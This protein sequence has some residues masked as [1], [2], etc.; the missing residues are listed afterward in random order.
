MLE[1]CELFTIL[2]IGLERGPD[3]VRWERIADSLPGR[4]N[5]DVRKRYVN[6]LHAPL[7]KGTWTPDEDERLREAV[8]TYDSRYRAT[9]SRGVAGMTDFMI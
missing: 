5:R 2:T 1:C 4:S 9:V 8:Q 7:N 3:A 6:V